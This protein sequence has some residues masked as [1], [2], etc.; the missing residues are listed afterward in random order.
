M[1]DQQKATSL[2][3]YSD[4]NSIQTTGLR[5]LAAAGTVFKT[6]YCPYPLCVPS[7][8]SM[9]SG[10]YPSNS[11]FVGNAPML[12][13]G[14]GEYDT[15]F[16]LAKRQG[17][18]TLLVGK[19]HAFGD[20]RN[21]PPIVDEVFDR[22]YATTHGARMTPQTNRDQPYVEEFLQSAPQ[23]KQLW[24][25]AI[26]PWNA[27][28]SV[29]ARMCQVACDY[30]DD[31]NADDKPKDIPFAMWL[32]FPDPHEFYQAPRD[33]YES[34]DPASIS[35]YPNQPPRDMESRAQ[36]IQF[37]HWYFGAGDPP[38]AMKLQLIRVYLAMCKNVDNQLNRVLTV[39][40]SWAN[41]KTPS[42]FTFR[43]TAI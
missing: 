2:D 38:D 20:M 7:R 35:L 3:F 34:I 29:T 21:P 5:R 30:L 28:Q 9:L 37:M 15:L 33:V 43:I 40:K 17:A 23:L 24:G 4:I 19:D 1:T 31:W 12:A 13:K 14:Q 39:W 16:Q 42:S 18:R 41:G 25:S 8:I 32:S 26:A 11:G 10:R 27:D 22:R 36:Y 6:G